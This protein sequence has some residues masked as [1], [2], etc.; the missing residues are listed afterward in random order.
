MGDAFSDEVFC[1]A[2]VA[3]IGAGLSCRR[4][5]GTALSADRGVCRSR[6]SDASPLPVSAPLAQSSNTIVSARRKAVPEGL[7]AAARAASTRNRGRPA[8]DR[9]RVSALVCRSPVRWSTRGMAWVVSLALVQ[10]FVANQGDGWSYTLAYL[11]R[12]FEPLRTAAETVPPDV[13]GAHLA[14]VQTRC[15]HRCE[16]H[17]S[18][19]RATGD[20]AFDPEPLG[21]DDLCRTAP[22]CHRRS[23]G[24]FRRCRKRV[25]A[26]RSD[27][28]SA[29]RPARAV[30]AS[31]TACARIAARAAA[32]GGGGRS[33]TTA[34]TTSAR[35]W[36]PA[37]T[38]SSSTSRASRRAAR[39]TAREGAPALRDVAGMLRSFNYA[40]WSALRRVAH[41]S[42]ELGPAGAARAG[43]GAA[44]ENRL[45]G[46]L[47]R[48]AVPARRWRSRPSPAAACSACS[49]SRRRSTN[50]ATSSATAPTGSACRCKDQGAARHGVS[51]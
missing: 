4:R 38:S 36:S 35:C 51:N 6:P 26:S 12:F 17:V 22:A 18:A 34:I 33:A 27:D 20:A 29:T 49:S 44:D 13:H 3:A 15:A 21:A 28:A 48:R 40:H 7:P 5:A 23:P 19:A 25:G 8:P 32:G 14:L 37:T 45:P 16:L 24:E 2:V 41:S 50:C 42:D 30:A 10:A 43:L 31:R 47:L 11:E 9:R 46:R 1:R 39:R